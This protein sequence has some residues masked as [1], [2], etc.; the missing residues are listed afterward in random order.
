MKNK[1]T[2]LQKLINLTCNCSLFKMNVNCSASLFKI[3]HSS[4]LIVWYPPPPPP[5]PISKHCLA[6]LPWRQNSNPYNIN[7]EH[8]RICG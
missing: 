8:L 5:P 6:F 4:F 2:T 3:I 1:A 7:C